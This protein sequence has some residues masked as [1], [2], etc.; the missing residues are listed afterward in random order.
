MTREATPRST[1]RRRG[2]SSWPGPIGY[3]STSPRGG[4]GLVL[5]LFDESLLA[6]GVRVAQGLEVVQTAGTTTHI[7]NRAFERSAS[8]IKPTS[9]GTACAGPASAA[10]VPPSRRIEQADVELRNWRIGAGG[11]RA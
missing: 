5:R 6:A 2:T 4:T 9:V 1:G 8:L 11:P 10:D 7:D 3:F